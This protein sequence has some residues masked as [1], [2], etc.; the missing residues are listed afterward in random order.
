M[1][2]IIC[3]VLA[4]IL[5]STICS[6]RSFASDSDDV[7]YLRNGNDTSL[8]QNEQQMI[9]YAESQVR[10][11]GITRNLSTSCT[12]DNY[13]LGCYIIILNIRSR[14]H[15]IRITPALTWRIHVF[16]LQSQS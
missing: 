3:I 4:V 6:F 9:D 15:I 11:K 7:V 10:K 2:K 8:L 14:Q 13:I 5:L 1:K 16:K 12:T